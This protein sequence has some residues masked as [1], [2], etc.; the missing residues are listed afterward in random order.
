ME[1]PVTLIG[2]FVEIYNASISLLT[3]QKLRFFIFCVSTKIK[4]LFLMIC[5]RISYR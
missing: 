4:L 3:K 5:F 1:A 2:A